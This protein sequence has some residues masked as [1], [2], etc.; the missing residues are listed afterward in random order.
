MKIYSKL[1]LSV[2]FNILLTLLSNI[3]V[4]YFT[5][6]FFTRHV[7]HTSPKLFFILLILLS[8]IFAYKGAKRRIFIPVKIT[9]ILMLSFT[10]SAT[11]VWCITKGYDPYFFEMWTLYSI[12]LSFP[13]G[14]VWMKLYI[15]IPIVTMVYLIFLNLKVLKSYFD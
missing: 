5:Y 3:L 13:M 6:S 1:D 14:F 15:V 8:I 10:I 7:V 9:V 4:I 11:I 2:K 12:L